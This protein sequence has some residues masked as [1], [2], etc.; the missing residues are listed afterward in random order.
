MTLS[1]LYTA[2][3]E[4]QRKVSALEAELT[5]CQSDIAQDQ[6]RLFHTE[7]VLSSLIA[8]RDHLREENERFRASN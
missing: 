2:Y 1:Q 8:E 3:R 7:C 6:H 4:L 5:H